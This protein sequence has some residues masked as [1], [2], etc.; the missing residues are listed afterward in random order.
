[1]S[2]C[3]IKFRKAP[4]CRLSFD[5]IPGNYGLLPLLSG[6]SPLFLSPSPE[7]LLCGCRAVGFDWGLY[8]ESKADDEVPQS[9]A[10]DPGHEEILRTVCEYYA[11]DEDALY[12]KKRGATNEPRNVSIY[13]IRRLRRDTLKEIGRQFKIEKYSSVSSIIER[14]RRQMQEDASFRKRIEELS[15]TLTKSQGQTP[16]SY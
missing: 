7:D 3:C 4:N 10:L 8:Y 11:V 1:M 13:L 15:S 6:L 5:Y 9:K 14:T 2:A 16:F 12:R